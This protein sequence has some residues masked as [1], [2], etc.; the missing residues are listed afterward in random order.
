MEMNSNT[1]LYCP[2]DDIQQHQILFPPFPEQ[3]FRE[4]FFTFPPRIFLAQPLHQPHR[5]QAHDH[6][7][8]SL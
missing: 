1:L 2:L 5:V 4:F 7:C 3:V 6:G 8:C